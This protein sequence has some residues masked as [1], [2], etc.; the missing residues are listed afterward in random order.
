MA[1][2]PCLGRRSSSS[3]GS[4]S[5]S[6]GTN[7]R[8]PPR[9]LARHLGISLA[10]C[11]IFLASFVLFLLVGLSV[12]IIKSI[13]IF[14]IQFSTNPSQPVTSVATDLQFGVWGVCAYSALDTAE[15]IGPS[16]G[17]TIPDAIAELTGFPAI[18][19]D[20]ARALTVLLILHIVAAALAFVVEV[21]SLFLESHGMCIFSL[22]VAVLAA[23][24]GT[25]VFAADIAIVLIA[26]IK[27]SALSEYTYAVTWGPAVWISLAGLV[28]LLVGMVLLCVVVCSCCGYSD[29]D[30]EDEKH[31][32]FK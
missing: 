19:D 2:T 22:V 23:I 14:Q 26:Q 6:D 32:F 7:K 29:L 25:A 24:L 27:I 16:L 31:A 21:T 8:R 11:A 18:V 20:V 13:Y 28:V 30:D 12:T 10:T 4:D 5:S 17:Y 9:P 15:C 1:C 3:G